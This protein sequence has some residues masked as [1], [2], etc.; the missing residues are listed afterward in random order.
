MVYYI[1]LPGDTEADTVRDSNILGEVV[2]NKFKRNQGYVVLANII[3]KYPDRLEG[4]RIID[5]AGKKYSV[6]QFLD[7]VFKYSYR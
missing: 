2:F 6:E 5:Q 4:V 3:N 1:L 7:I